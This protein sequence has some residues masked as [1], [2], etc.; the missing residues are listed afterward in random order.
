MAKTVNPALFIGLGGTGHKVL[1]QVK[2][3]VLKNYGEVPKVIKILSLDTDVRELTSSGTEIEYNKKIKDSNN[4]VAW[5]NVVENIKF[6]NREILP[7]PIK[8]PESIIDQEN[9]KSWISPK[10]TRISQSGSGAKQIRQMGRFSIFENYASEGIRK[11]IKDKI[12]EIKNLENLRGEGY[13]LG[14]SDFKPT[15]HLVC[16]PCGGTGA[17]TFIDIVTIIREIDDNIKINAYLML[18]DFYSSYP[19]TESV[20]PNAYCTLKEIDHLMGRDRDD[21]K[22]WFNYDVSKPFE[23]DY[24]GQGSKFKFSVSSKFVDYIYL[25]DNY[26]AKKKYI[27]KDSDMHDR[28]AR[29]CYL[30]VSGTA[31]SMDTMYSNDVDS[32][33]PSSAKFNYKRR[34]YS[35]MG[36]SEIILNRK[37]LKDLKKNQISR[38]ILNAYAHAEQPLDN[39]VLNNFIDLN[40]WRED[41]GKDSLIDRL[42]PKN[43]LKYSL[44]SLYHKFKK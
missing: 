17:G 3:A 28:I 26:N 12:D 7:I 42:M 32:L 11:N 9:I 15:I 38:A 37:F 35:S 13:D 1:L 43:S 21:E 8:N 5:Q 4:E 39:S 24:T 6:D 31:T 27:A 19:M 41:S 20:V 14:N 22:P 36:I 33:Y 29:I 44:D 18:P 10:V 30:L 16:S 23:V 2:E 40:V 34:N 25:F